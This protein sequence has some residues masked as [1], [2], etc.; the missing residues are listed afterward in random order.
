MIRTNRGHRA[1]ITKAQA[2]HPWG[3][4][5]TGNFMAELFSEQIFNVLYPANNQPYRLATGKPPI[6]YNKTGNQI[7]LRRI[8]VFF[9]LTKDGIAD[10]IAT[11]RRNNDGTIVLSRGIDRYDNPNSLHACNAVDDFGPHWFTIGPGDGLW[12][13]TSANGFGAS[14][15]AQVWV[16][17]MW[18]NQH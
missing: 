3:F 9:G 7:Y 10:Y 11:V 5:Q 4:T 13:D 6:W 2:C 17:I 18:S 15:M 14:L 8:Q 16:I 12:I 1:V